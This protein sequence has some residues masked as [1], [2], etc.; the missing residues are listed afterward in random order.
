[1]QYPKSRRTLSLQCSI[2]LRRCDSDAGV[3][4]R[5]KIVICGEIICSADGVLPTDIRSRSRRSVSVCFQ[6]LTQFSF[7]PQ[8]DHSFNRQRNASRHV[9]ST[10]G[11]RKM[12]STSKGSP[13]AN[14]I[15]H[16]VIQNHQISRHTEIL[17]LMPTRGRCQLVVLCVRKRDCED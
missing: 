10:N 17:S 9:S 7:I 13:F 11:G 6:V 14:I 8:R 4:C 5:G 1:M 12:S 16:E 3:A 2:R 15:S